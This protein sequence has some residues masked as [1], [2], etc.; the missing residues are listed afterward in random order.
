MLI[1]LTPASE[2]AFGSISNAATL[3]HPGT[4][5]ARQCVQGDNLEAL[6]A[7]LAV[8]TAGVEARLAPREAE[9]EVRRIEHR[10][11]PCP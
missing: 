4:V 7:L 10:A 8:I 5:Q 9:K 2:T 3:D 1:R 6:R 11:K